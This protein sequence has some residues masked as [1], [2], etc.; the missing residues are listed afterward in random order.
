MK[1]S[2]EILKKIIKEELDQQAF[3]KSV[4]SKTDRAK[5]LKSKAIDNDSQKQ[6]DNLERGIIKQFTDRL[7]KLAELSNI[8]SGNVN[9]LLKRVYAIMDKEIQKLEGGDQKDEK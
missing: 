1:I 8:K 7:Q 2:K 6:I 5:D 4:V 3:G 9:S